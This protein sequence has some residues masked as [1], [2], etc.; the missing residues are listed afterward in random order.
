[1]ITVLYDLLGFLS[2]HTRE[3]LQGP[4]GFV[5]FIPLGLLGLLICNLLWASTIYFICFPFRLIWRM[6][7]ERVGPKSAAEQLWEEDW[8]FP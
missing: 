1:M 7:S 4:M 8:M 6:I 3:Q 5:L 2:E